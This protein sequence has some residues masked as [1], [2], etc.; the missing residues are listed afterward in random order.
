MEGAWAMS[1]ITRT[2]AISTPKIRSRDIDQLRSNDARLRAEETN[3]RA[4]GGDIRNVHYTYTI[5]PDGKRYASS[6]SVTYE[7]PTNSPAAQGG[8]PVMNPLER[9]QIPSDETD[10]FS[11]LRAAVEGYA[12]HAERSPS[13]PDGLSPQEQLEVRRLQETDAK[14]RSHEAAHQA[15]AGAMGGPAQ[16]EYVTGPDGKEYAVVGSVPISMAASGSPEEILASLDRMAA[17]ASAPGDM[18]AQDHAV[19]ARASAMR[20]K[21]TQEGLAKEAQKAYSIWDGTKAMPSFGMRA[22][23]Q[24]LDIAA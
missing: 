3:I 19:L 17:A 7:A 4:T 15:A 8:T 20:S 18:S 24:P 1:P 21:V 12:E 13:N 11:R 2:A 16:F 10:A 9:D 6:V 14:V 23:Y 22:D 5:G